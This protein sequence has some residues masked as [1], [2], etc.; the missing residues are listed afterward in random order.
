MKIPKETAYFHYLN[1]NPK[2][3]K[4]GDCVIR[5]LTSA[6]RIPYFDVLDGLVETSKKYGYS[7]TSVEN[8]D[9][10]LKILGYAKKKQL[11]KLDNTKYTGEEFAQY[12]TDNMYDIVE[13]YP[14]IANIG[15]H[16]VTVFITYDDVVKCQDVWNPTDFTVGNYWVKVL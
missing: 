1:E 8:Y 12:L 14:I 9:R 5:A 2:N 10:Y 16:H 6:L 11:R 13:D 3:R 15:S 7:V 4:T